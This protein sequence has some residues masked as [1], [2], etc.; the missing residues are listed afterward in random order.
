M[1][2]FEVS[3]V[4]HQWRDAFCLLSHSWKHTV[5]VYI[6]TIAACFGPVM[7][8]TPCPSE[9]EAQL[10]QRDRATLR[11][12]EYF[13]KSLEVTQGHWKWHC[14]VGRVQVRFQR[15]RFA[16]DNCALQIGFMLYYVMLVFHWNYVCM[17]Y[18]LWDIQRQ[19]M[20]WP[21]NWG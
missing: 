21:W 12:I 5:A 16:C 10:S 9:Q 17:S 13:A 2:M 3:L 11:V 7:Q 8:H 15:I 6:S 14:W 4:W 20:A 1:Y 18:R 19:R